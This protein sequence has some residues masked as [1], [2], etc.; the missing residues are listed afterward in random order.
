[1]GD[2]EKFRPA[3]QTFREGVFTEAILHVKKWEEEWGF[4]VEKYKH[5]EEE[6]AKADV[7]IK[8]KKKEEVIVDHPK[9]PV[10]SSRLIGWLVNDSRF[11]LERFGRYSRPIRFLHKELEWPIEGCP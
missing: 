10:T 9:Y 2:E 11:C 3:Q 4:L 6:T 1:M 5:L 8:S 7:F